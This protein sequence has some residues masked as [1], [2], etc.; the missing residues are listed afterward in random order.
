LHDAYID[1]VRKDWQGTITHVGIGGRFYEVM[2]IAHELL[3]K[4][5][6]LYTIENNQRARV[7][8]DEVP[9]EIDF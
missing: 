1:C 4:R 2:H 3:D 8:L 5:Y 9:V 7:S 6:S